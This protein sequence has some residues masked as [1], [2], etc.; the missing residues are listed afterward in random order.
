MSFSINTNLSAMDALSN[1]SNT[2]NMLSQSITRLS[3]GLR[4]NSAA[5]DPSGLIIANGFQ[6]QLSGVTQAI[7]NSQ[8][9]VNY[10]KTAEGGLSQVNTLLNS[11]R[12]LAVAAGNSG[13]LTSSQI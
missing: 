1:V 3:T 6:A 9:A 10:V 5:D 7:S 4:I 2:S 11:A 8:D 12:S 13:T